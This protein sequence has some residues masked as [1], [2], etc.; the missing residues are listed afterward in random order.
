[1][2]KKVQKK[3]LLSPKNRK[4]GAKMRKLRT[5]MAAIAFLL[6]LA[7]SS[8]SS[9]AAPK[10]KTANDY[11]TTAIS[12]SQKTVTVTVDLNQKSGFTSGQFGVCYDPEQLVFEYAYYNNAMGL[13]DV[14]INE[15]GLVLYAWADEKADNYSERL[16][17]ITF[18]ALNAYNG[19]KV[20]V[21]TDVVEGYQNFKAL[22]NGEDKVYT[23]TLKLPN[24]NSF[25]G[26][27]DSWNDYRCNIY[28]VFNRWFWGFSHFFW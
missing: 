12:S 15:D 4:D 26:R 14:N 9:F 16:I 2:K 13:V 17:T 11:F 6:I 18:T 1:M 22:T 8:M 27:H 21:M 10:A 19:E 7:F 23:T 28:N 5:S 3:L 25:W 24:S 20:S